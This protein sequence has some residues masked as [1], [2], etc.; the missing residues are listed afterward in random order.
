MDNKPEPLPPSVVVVVVVEAWSVVSMEE[1]N[2]L[3]CVSQQAND[4][5]SLSPVSPPAARS[6][7]SGQWPG[8]AR[9]P[10]RRCDAVEVTELASSGVQPC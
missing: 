5:S 10:S 3:T 2:E 4:L 7:T 1:S 9:P 6:R 8:P